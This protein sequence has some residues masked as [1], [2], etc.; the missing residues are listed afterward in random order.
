MQHVIDGQTET[1]TQAASPTV[2]SPVTREAPDAV[3]VPTRTVRRYVVD[4]TSTLRG[5][6]LGT[7]P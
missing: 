1:I 7:L 4:P 5:S 3:A 6:I 2:R